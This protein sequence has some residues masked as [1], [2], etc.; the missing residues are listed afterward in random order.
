MVS[1]R[2]GAI[3]LSITYVNSC[4]DCEM[5]TGEMENTSWLRAIGSL[6]VSATI[7]GPISRIAVR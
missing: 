5:N 3:G 1:F 2:I 6:A 7:D 4:F